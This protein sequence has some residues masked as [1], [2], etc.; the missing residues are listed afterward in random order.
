[1]EAL[2]AAGKSHNGREVQLPRRKNRYRGAEADSGKSQQRLGPRLYSLRLSGAGLFCVQRAFAAAGRNIKISHLA[3]GPHSPAKGRQRGGNGDVH[4]APSEK[5]L[6]RVHISRGQPLLGRRDPRL[7]AGHGKTG[8]CKRRHSC[9]IS[10]SG[11]V[12]CQSPVGRAFCAK[13][14][15]KRLCCGGISAGNAG[16]NVP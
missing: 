5:R 2:P 8:P 3:A 11:C 16:K 4:V 6:Q 10:H 12:F 7:S 9:N 1:M 14:S 13:R 15:C